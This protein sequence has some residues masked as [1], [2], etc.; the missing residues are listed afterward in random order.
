MTVISPDELRVLREDLG[1]TAAQMGRFVGRTAQ[2]IYAWESRDHDIDTVMGAVLGTLRREYRR[3]VQLCTREE[4]DG[5]LELLE[6]KGGEHFILALAARTHASREAHLRDLVRSAQKDG[7]TV[8]PLSDGRR[9]IFVYPLT[10]RSSD[11]VE[12]DP[13]G[14]R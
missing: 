8:V 11:G 4:V 3:R 2:T 9:S 10:P 12:N 14:R 13:D 6:E 5:W 7:G 1:W